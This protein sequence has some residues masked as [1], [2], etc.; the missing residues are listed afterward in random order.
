MKESK[1]SKSKNV[2][3]N[4]YTTQEVNEK[5][6]EIPEYREFFEKREKG[7]TL[8]DMQTKQI[9]ASK[10]IIK[11]YEGINNGNYQEPVQNTIDAIKHMVDVMDNVRIQIQINIDD[12]YYNFGIERLARV[13]YGLNKSGYMSE[14]DYK[15]SIDLNRRWFHHFEEMKMIRVMMLKNQISWEEMDALIDA[16]L[17]K[18]IIIKLSELKILCQPDPSDIQN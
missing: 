14:T 16:V 1:M 6:L 5:I 3:H 7:F 9:D 15:E 13:L 8:V 11:Q 12:E 4:A 10:E 17:Q 2:G 18:P